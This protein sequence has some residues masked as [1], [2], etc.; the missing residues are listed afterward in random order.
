M[1]KFKLSPPAKETSMHFLILFLISSNVL[2][3]IVQTLFIYF[4]IS[5]AQS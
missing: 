1:Q 2:F 5:H 4:L 3:E